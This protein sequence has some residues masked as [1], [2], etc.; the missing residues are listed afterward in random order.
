MKKVYLIP[1]IEIVH[2]STIQMIAGSNEEVIE[3][4]DNYGD[5]SGISLGG[6]K[7]GDIWDEE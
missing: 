3:Q 1:E 2:V 6:R 5:G 7:S 4:K